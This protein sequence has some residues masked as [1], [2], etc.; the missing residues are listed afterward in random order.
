MTDPP[1]EHVLRPVPP[2]R[3]EGKTECGLDIEGRPVLTRDEF[4][5]KVKTQGQQRSAM[6]TCMTCWNTA[7]RWPSWDVDPAGC[8]ARDTSGWRNSPEFG[9]E[10]RAIALLIEAHPDEFRATMDGLRSA[11]PIKALRQ[12]RGHRRG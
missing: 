7:Q 9:E 5:A 4:V 10:L 2:W 11:V 6:S 1:K 8:V 3:S 12:A